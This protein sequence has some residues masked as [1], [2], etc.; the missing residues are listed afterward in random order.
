MYIIPQYMVSFT[1]LVRKIEALAG[2]HIKSY[3]IESRL[4]YAIFRVGSPDS[5]R[6][7]YYSDVYFVV[8]GSGSGPALG[9]AL[10]SQPVMDMELFYL[11]TLHKLHGTGRRGG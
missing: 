9:S 11:T 10:G 6:P 3:V 1:P 7:Q 5:A 2:Q 8:N 4:S